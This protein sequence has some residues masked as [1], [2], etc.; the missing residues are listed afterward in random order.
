MMARLRRL[1]WLALVLLVAVPGLGGAALQAVHPCPVDAPWLAAA[2]STPADMP[3]DT[4]A[5]GHH[6]APAGA[7]SH[8]AGG[9]GDVCHCVGACAAALAPAPITD[10][11]RILEI[12]ADVVAQ[13]LVAPAAEL[14][15][16]APPL[17]RLPPTTAP[18]RL[19]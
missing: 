18:P 8:D 2:P 11:G 19:G 12:D 13:V 5:H 15:P 9:H 14:P 17:D 1:R 6:G 4:P 10:A 16:A 3:A 7:P